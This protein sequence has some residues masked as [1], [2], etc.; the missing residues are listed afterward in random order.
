LTKREEKMKKAKAKIYEARR[1]M[2]SLEVV[3]W[4]GLVNAHHLA[5]RIIKVLDQLDLTELYGKIISK[6]THQGRPA[7][8][9]KIMLAVW[10]YAYM[11]GISSSRVVADY[12]KWEPGFRWI[13]GYDLRVQYVALSDF[14]KNLGQDLEHMLTRVVTLMVASGVVDLDEVILDGTKV[15]ASAGSRSFRTEKELQDLQDQVS[16]KIKNLDSEEHK[17]KQRA[18]LEKKKARIEKGLTQIPEIQKACIETAKKQKKGTEAKEAKASSTDPDARKMH[19]SD[20]SIKPGYNP[21]IMTTS[22]S[23]IIVDVKTTQERNDSN[24]M[25]P[26]L[27][28]FKSRYGRYPKRFLADSHYPVK[29]DV[30]EALRSKIDVYCPAPKERKN[31]KEESKKRLARKRAKESQELKDWR[32]KMETEE[33]KV[34]RKRR[35]QTEKV[36]GWMKSKM[37]FCQLKLRGLIG[38]QTEILLFAIGYNLKRYFNLA[39]LKTV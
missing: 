21:Q 27:D 6:T 14:R 28:S 9:P 25:S 30:E 23:G 35:G 36:H 16:E 20:G 37:P 17:Q 39:S 22:K 34:V 1:N 2:T 5:R 18:A 38:A 24:L 19:F 13:L 26:M 8:D 10:I 29:K 31:S 32:A 15:K 33:A 3:D 4:S 7:I 11:Q 12:C